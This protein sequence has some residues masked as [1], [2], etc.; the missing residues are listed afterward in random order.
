MVYA[1]GSLA[2]DASQSEAAETYYV[3]ALE[4]L[5]PVL[6]LDGLE[7]IQALLSIAVYSV[8]SPSGMSLWKVSGMAMRLCVQ[9][10]Y[11]RNVEKY[12]SAGD[13]LTKEMSKRCFWVAYDLDRYVSCILGLPGAISDLSIDVEV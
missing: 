7:S 5:E 1:I 10:G 2:A 13:V 3:A 8:R 9:L 12:R 6:D 11:H 4:Y